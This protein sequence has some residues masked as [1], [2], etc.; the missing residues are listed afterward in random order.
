MRD[1]LP[2]PFLNRMRQLLGDEYAPFLVSYDSPPSV[3]LRVHT[4]KLSPRYFQTISP[5]SLIPV[6]G[7]P[8][9]FLLPPQARPGK[10]PYHTAGLYYLQ[11]PAAMAVVALMDPQPG[12]RI[13]DLAAAPGGKA[14]HIAARMQGEG[15]LVANDQTPTGRMFSSRIWSAGEHTTPSSPVRRPP[16]WGSILAPAS[17]AFSSMRPAPG[18]GCSARAP[19][20]EMPGGRSLS[21]IPPAS[22]MPSWQPPRSWF[23][24]AGCSS[25]PPAPSPPRKMKG[26]WPDFWSGMTISTCLILPTWRLA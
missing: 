22:R 16:G 2:A 15:L 3:G 4:G 14:T 1:N 8:E 13:L 17:T 25:T 20:L 9:G 6:P 18:R 11:D 7:V 10:H 19:R 12:E 21:K 23:A 5:F 26:R 24:P